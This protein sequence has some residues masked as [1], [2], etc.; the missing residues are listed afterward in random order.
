[1]SRAEPMPPLVL[2]YD[3]DAHIAREVT[4]AEAL[5]GMLRYARRF[6]AGGVVRGEIERQAL[7]AYAPSRSAARARRQASDG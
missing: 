5:E 2:V 7:E 3:V 1:M 4:P 6:T